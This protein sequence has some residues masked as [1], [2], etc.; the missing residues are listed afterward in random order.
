MEALPE[1]RFAGRQLPPWK[2]EGELK[3]ARTTPT[4][5]SNSE[6]VRPGCFL[7]PALKGGQHP[8]GKKARL[9]H[10]SLGLAGF[11]LGGFHTNRLQSSHTPEP[12]AISIFP[13][14]SISKHQNG[15]AKAVL[16]IRG[17]IRGPVHAGF[18]H[19]ARRSA[20]MRMGVWGCGHDLENNRLKPVTKRLM[21]QA[22]QC[23]PTLL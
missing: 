10:E 22:W 16:R 1:F 7:Q 13:V 9:N 11:G 14:A 21:R 19:T 5:I 12:L 23:T 20:V 15:P 2:M 3:A 8:T 18:W 6:A 17:Y 4:Y